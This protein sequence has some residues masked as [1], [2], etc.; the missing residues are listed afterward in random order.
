MQD[1]FVTGIVFFLRGLKAV[2]S[3]GFRRFI[4]LP[5]L[6][7]LVLLI[8][9][10]ILL[11]LYFSR[12]FSGFMAIYPGWLTLLLGWLF[13]FVFWIM[14]IF[15]ATLCFTFLTNILAS[16]FYGLLAEKIEQHS[17]LFPTLSTMSFWRS[18]PH[19][20]YREGQK[21]WHF[22]PWLLLC[23]LLLILPP[24]YPIAPFVWWV[25]LAWIL[26]IQYI[27]YVADNQQVD[28]KTMLQKLKQKPFTA[29][30]F[31][32]SVTL[33]MTIPGINL[34]VPPAAVAGGTFLWL[35]LKPK[36]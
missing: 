32:A 21:L 10:I 15:V 8:G 27:D 29:L 1:S 24:T 36:N 4:I 14:S 12:H 17:S 7:N 20:L 6:I 22:I 13:W 26:A 28:L 19:I 34:V 2:L 30:G 33:L 5:I 3:P 16:P 11:A 18:I 25:V 9:C 35:S 31:G 23:L